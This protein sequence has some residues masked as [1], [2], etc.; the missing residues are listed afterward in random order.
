MLGKRI[1]NIR[2][3][4]GTTQENLASRAGIGR[5]TLGRIERGEQ[6]P[7]YETLLAIAGGLACS[8]QSLIVDDESEDDLD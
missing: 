6:S 5:I 4:S 8:V 1:R 3:T 7:R 2:R